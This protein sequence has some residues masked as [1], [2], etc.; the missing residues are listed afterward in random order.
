[1]IRR[2]M[3]LSRRSEVHAAQRAVPSHAVA[4]RERLG[5]FNPMNGRGYSTMQ[6]LEPNQSPLDPADW[7]D[8][9]AQAHRLLDACID[10]LQDARERC[11]FPS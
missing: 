11:Y 2:L 7:E 8:Y 10:H 9:R 6:T 5:V 4:V 3:A 1:M